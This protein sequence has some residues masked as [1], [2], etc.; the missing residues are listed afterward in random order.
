MRQTRKARKARQ[1]G[2][3][4]FKVL[5]LPAL[6]LP[7]LIYA[8]WLG[9]PRLAVSA[10]DSTTS[11][12]PPD[13]QTPLPSGEGLT[14]APD[15]TSSTLRISFVGDILLGSSV[16]DLIKA[17]GP[18][19]PWLGVKDL[20]SASDLTCGNLE[21]PIGTV[22]TAVEG[23][24]YTFRADPVVVEGLKESGIDVVSLAN[25]HALDYGPECMLQTIDL[26]RQR[27]I[28]VIGAGADEPAA[29]T[30]FIFEKNGLKVGILATAEL[31]P[32]P[33]WAAKE[34][35]PGLAVDYYGWYPGIVSSIRALASQVDTVIVLIHWGDERTTA[36][37]SRLADLTEALRDAGADAVIGT[38]PHI[39]EGIAYD[40]HILTAYSLGN[41]V[42]SSRP[43]V[44]A[45]QAGAVLT[46]TVSKGKVDSASVVPTNIAWGK[47]A[48]SE[49]TD[50]DATIRTLSTLSRPFGTDV[51]PDG[52][53]VPVPFK[54][55]RTHWARFSAGILVSKSS[56]TGYPDDTFRPENRIT[57][58]EFAAMF[59]RLVAT[60]EEIDTA[61]RPDGFCL[62][63]DDSWSYPY[64]R[65]LA[66]TGAISPADPAW[67]GDKECSRQE[68]CSAM[69][70]Y[71]THPQG[72]AEQDV[73]S[74]TWAMEQGILRGDPGG[75]LRLD[76]TVTRAE[77]AEVLLRY[78][79]IY[80]D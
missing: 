24:T 40:G 60:Q 27:G 33:T 12:P 38:H 72:L 61:A 18:A 32:D 13:G 70:R 10:A 21:C 22:G 55:M 52:D 28:A 26:V 78:L 14:P 44:P 17:E 58:A 57:K 51:S 53:V 29:R 47:T 42:F 36:P 4:G 76:E 67:A 77:M 50:R 54:D 31:V 59:S 66:A 71:V 37:V 16:G 35:S 63:S 75:A 5:V 56:I 11:A 45:L 3:W 43:D 25:N 19:A 9:F 23:K 74:V 20:L 49:G 79:R 39:L 69:W 80:G 1:R 48:V 2:H 41:F 62:C 65:F 7:I 30:P 6:L 73:S 34:D 46:L 15:R 68:A 64:L 8:A